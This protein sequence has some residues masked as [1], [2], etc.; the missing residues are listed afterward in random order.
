V[1]IND[2]ASKVT[3]EE[4][5]AVNLTVAQ[6]SE[7]LAIVNKLLWGIPYALIKLRRK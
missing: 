1:K 3:L 4:G 2:F 7:V 6:V 5:G